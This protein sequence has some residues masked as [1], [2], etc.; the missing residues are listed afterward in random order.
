M[1]E[2]AVP[3]CTLEQAECVPGLGWSSSPQ[4]ISL[5]FIES[6]IRKNGG[7]IWEN[8]LF[9]ISGNLRVG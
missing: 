6:R 7:S 4:V 9:C 3:T 2:D 1:S 8:L 5:I